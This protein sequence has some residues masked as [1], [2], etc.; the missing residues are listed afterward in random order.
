MKKESSSTI[1]TYHIPILLIPDEIPG[2]LIQVH[3]VMVQTLTAENCKL[4]LSSRQLY[5]LTCM[6][7]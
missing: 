2:T 3:K 1:D 5:T 7:F 6:I 4:L